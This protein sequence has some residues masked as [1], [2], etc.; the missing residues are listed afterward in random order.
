MQRRKDLRPTGALNP[1]I[2]RKAFVL[3][4][5]FRASE[6]SRQAPMQYLERANR[7]GIAFAA[8]SKWLLVINL[9]IFSIGILPSANAEQAGTIPAMYGDRQPFL[10]AIDKERASQRSALKITGISVP[11]HML[12]ADLIARG[13]W[14]ASGNTYDR[15]I[16]LS[17]DHFGKSRRPFA[18]THADFDTPF[19]VALNDLEATAKLSSSDQ[20]FEDSDLFRN[21]H[22]IA[23]ILPFAK[24]FFPNAK[25]VPIVV[26][27]RSDRLD[28]DA[29]FEAMRGLITD[30]TL[31]VQS[32]DYSHYLPLATAIQRDQETLNVIAAGDTDALNGLVQP[33]HMDSKGSQYI[34]MR[35]QREQ[36]NA[37]PIVI[38]N[39][40]SIE[41]SADEKVTT[42]YI[43]TVYLKDSE[44]GNKLRYDDQEIFYFGGDAFLG[45]WLTAPLAD[46]AISKALIQRLLEVTGG[47]PIILNLEGV[48]LDELPPGL[49]RDLHAM[50]AELAIKTLRALNVRA[51]SFANN[52]SL[53]LGELA[54][55]RSVKIAR[56]SAI[57]PLEHM[58]PVDWGKFGIVAIN[59]IKPSNYE[60]FPVIRSNNELMKLCRTKARFPLIAFVHWG[61]EFRNTAEMTQYQIADTFHSCGVNIII[62]A[63]SHRA[64]LNVEARLGGEYQMV[65]SLG[66]LLFDQRASRASNAMLEFRL[67]RQGTIATRLIALPNLYDLAVPPRIPLL[68]GEP[69]E[70]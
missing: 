2:V 17:P 61:K 3:A 30:R 54:Y 42:S 40:N 47:F 67:F 11:H 62:G 13:F 4:I 63:H 65:Y 1:C 15:I 5:A 59:F 70:K 35:L 19:G 50:P 29:A 27:Y 69:E 20:L 9:V 36:T 52:H 57:T 12:A 34:Q 39:R 16:V 49:N 53:D 55:K 58:R 8:T 32:T 6:L 64:S 48:L 60:D 28:W 56:R 31:V 14:A 25:I 37:T 18:T 22:G 24:Y 21:E 26:S 51:V 66:N 46:G 43:V 7:C 23:A 33:K 10:T 38:A 45:R 68:T 44:E 41:Y